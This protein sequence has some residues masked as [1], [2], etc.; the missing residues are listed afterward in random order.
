MSR[1]IDP[2]DYTKG[3]VKEAGQELASFFGDS[4]MTRIRRR[5]KNPQTLADIYVNKVIRNSICRYFPN[6]AIKTEET[7]DHNPFYWNYQS[8]YVWI[9]DPCDGTIN[10]ISGI[11]FFSVSIALSY[12]RKVI[13]G[14]VY[15]PIRDEMFSAELANGAKLNDSLIRV[16]RKRRISDATF[17][18]DIYPDLG[19]I[20]KEVRLLQI[21]AG[22]VR[23]VRSFYSGALELSYLA[24]GR[25]DIR[26]DDSYKPW[27]VAAGQLIASEAGAKLTDINNKPWSLASRSL[28]AANPILH[29]MVIQLL[30]RNK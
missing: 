28:L 12:K 11:P 9:V 26:V 14:V 24:A 27:D 18:I 29:K 17:G 19:L 15:D 22:K 21:L 23:V 20:D 5:G 10:Y 2:I 3:I 30:K 1:E 4:S 16:S 8:D 7:K 13:M 6:H 25:I